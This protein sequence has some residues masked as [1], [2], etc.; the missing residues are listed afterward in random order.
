MTIW[1]VNNDE[2][3]II[4]DSLF[5]LMEYL[6]D[7]ENIEMI[8][9]H[10]TQFK[11]F[12]MVTLEEYTGKDFVVNVLCKDKDKFNNF[13]T[14]DQIG[15]IQHFIDDTYAYL[16]VWQNDKDTINC[17]MFKKFFSRSCIIIEKDDS[18]KY[19]NM[20]ESLQNDPDIPRRETFYVDLSTQSR[21]ENQNLNGVSKSI[22]AKNKQ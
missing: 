17:D 1:S 8:F 16:T 7:N 6:K 21:I 18:C 13:E 4:Y 20:W 9:I 3:N 2:A 5:K 12:N 10:I 22:C 14:F 15:D 11:K 19:Y